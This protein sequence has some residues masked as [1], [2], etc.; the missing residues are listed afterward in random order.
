MR[1]LECS[2]TPAF[3][4]AVPM[5]FALAAC[6]VSDDAPLDDTSSSAVTLEGGTADTSTG[7][8]TEAPECEA[9]ADC[10][11]HPNGPVCDEATGQCFPDCEPGDVDPACYEGPGNTRGEGLCTDG[12]RTCQE[13]GVW[14]PCLGQVLPELEICGNELDE[15]CNGSLV[16][17]DL[18]GDGWTTCDNDCCDDELIGCLDAEFVNPGAFEVEGNELDDDCDGEVDEPDLSCDAGLNSNSG[19][20]LDY[21][22][23]MDLC[24]TTVEDA[25]LPERTWGVISANLTLADGTLM[26]LPVQRSIRAG[27]G[28]NI[29]P[30]GGESLVILSSG[31]AADPS[32]S[33]PAHQPFESGQDLG[34]GV[35]APQDWINANGGEFP[36]SCEGVNPNPN[37][38]A[39][40]SVMLTLR[41]RVPTNARSFT[42]R[43]FFFSAEYPEWVCSPY[44]DFFVTLIDSQSVDNPDDK[45]IAVYTSEGTTWPVGLNILK[46][47]PGLFS[48]CQSGNVGCQGDL[49]QEAFVCADGPE[50]LAGTGFD[51]IDTGNSC[52]GDGF[53]VGGGTGWLDMSGNVEPGEIM[54]IRFAVWDAGGHL[55][56]ALVLLDD[57]RW[58]LDAAAPGI[59]IP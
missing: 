6:P 42:T 1:R 10:A 57:W 24:Q 13:D 2:L 18:D 16:A 17:E 53:F 30:S 50:L 21:A 11:D 29:V 37:T 56:D 40:D 44:N 49:P 9:D 35:P 43:M 12:S 54:D 22:A 4:L 46:T 27:F 25:P 14:G 52:N 7:E 32:Q 36:A 28:D 55:F 58:S 59:N 33:Q 41:M 5:V 8:D 51:A 48:V 34:T 26:P 19:N 45:N 38:E 31:N 20:G 23:A 39:N 3:T 47:A 15:D